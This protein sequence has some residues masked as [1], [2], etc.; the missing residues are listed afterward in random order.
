MLVARDG[1]VAWSRV[2]GFQDQSKNQP[3]TKDS[4]FRIYSMTKP[5]VSVAIMMLVEEGKVALDTP[6]GKIQ[7]DA[8]LAMIALVGFFYELQMLFQL[9]FR[10]KACA[11]NPLKHGVLFVPTPIGAGDRQ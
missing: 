2:L 11:I 5:I 8:K 4:L 7:F 3:M 6:V 10:R 9:L 1:K